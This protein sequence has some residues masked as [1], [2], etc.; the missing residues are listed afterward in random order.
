M[1]PRGQVLYYGT[2][3]VRARTSVRP[4]VRLVSAPVH[5]PTAPSRMDLA[6]QRCKGCRRV[7]VNA[8]KLHGHLARSARCLEAS[9]SGSAGASAGG[10]ANDSEVAITATEAARSG[11][12]GMRAN[13]CE[14]LASLRFS[15]RTPVSES[16]IQVVKDFMKDW[17]QM[18]RRSL[19]GSVLPL[20]PGPAAREQVT[21]N[22]R[23]RLGWLD[24]LGTRKLE[25]AF[26]KDHLG[27]SLKPPLRRE[28]PIKKKKKRKLDSTG[29]AKEFD[30]CWVM[31]LLK[32]IQ[33]RIEHDSEFR[34]E[35]LE[36]SERWSAREEDVGS[37]QSSLEKLQG[38]DASA[39]LADF[40]VEN[41]MHDVEP[42][43]LFRA[44]PRLGREGAIY[45]RDEHGTEHRVVKL[46]FIAYLDGIE[47]AN[48]LGVAR[49]SQSMECIYV[50]LLNLP[51]TAC[52]TGWR[53]SSRSR[54]ATRRRSSGSARVP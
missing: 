49:G 15:G 40:D 28:L 26:L 53:I 21:G 42:G 35:L 31:S 4:T 33:A 32:Q 43:L 20:L 39:A 2:S 17:L 12:A 52:A 7:F 5:A 19:E 47:T 9:V 14:A 22:F 50:A 3:T 1:A 36:S 18:T 11:D 25:M 46:R 41:E 37:L 6:S 38:D 23:S 16:A 27:A 51:L 8:D 34:R 30:H 24:G 13:V 10:I 54:Y 45:A 44:H 48:P 29:G